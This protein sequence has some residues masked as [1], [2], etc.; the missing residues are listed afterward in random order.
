MMIKSLY[1]NS[2]SAVLLNNSEGEF[3]KTSVGVR[4]TSCTTYDCTTY[5]KYNV[6]Q[7]CLLSPILFNLFL[8]EIMSET[9]SN[10]SSSI[11]VG[12]RPLWNLN[13][14]DDIDLL[15]GTNEELQ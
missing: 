13:F 3:F 11:S 5:V 6:R 8:K 7:G 12:G 1:A 4:R 10:Y 14:A 9:Q 15:A 2:T